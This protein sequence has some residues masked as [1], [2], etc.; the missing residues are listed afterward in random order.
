M[1]GIRSILIVV[2]LAI[3]LAGCGEE[4]IQEEVKT[5]GS[6]GFR[7]GDGKAD[8]KA[9]A[10]KPGAAKP[11]APKGKPGAVAT[12]DAEPEE[13][14]G[15]QR[16]PVDLDA[17]SFTRRRDPFQSFVVA[18]KVELE[19][20][21]PR[22]ERK[23]VLGE[24]SFEDLKLIAIVNSGRQIVPRALFVGSDGRSKAVRQGEYFSSAEVLL[25]AVN[26]DYVEI[27]IVDE[28]LASSLNMQRGERRA[29]YLRNE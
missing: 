13:D 14:P 27:E 5:R 18:Q 28:E 21:K 10:A 15:L 29:I 25:A 4:G 7:G 6:P 16:P 2:P 12:A 9:G 26:R 1:H 8:A 22:A 3:A 23:V 19:P 11:A 24:Y 20:D 17:K